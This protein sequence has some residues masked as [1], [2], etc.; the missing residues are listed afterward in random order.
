MEL[1]KKIA[2]VTGASR[3][4]GATTALVF[5]KMGAW[6]ALAARDKQALEEVADQIHKLG[7]EALVVPIDVAN[8]DAVEYLVRTTMDKFGQLNIAFNNGAGCGH[9]PT[10]LAKVIKN[11][12]YKQGISQPVLFIGGGEEA[13]VKFGSLELMKRCPILEELW[14]C[15]VVVT[16]FSKNAQPK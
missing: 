15:P 1:D 3:G 11:E 6:V 12:L 9:R 4:I 13:A 2:L 16:G 7:S 14:R 10:P 8:A 5:A